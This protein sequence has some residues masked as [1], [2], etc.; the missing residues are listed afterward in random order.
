MPSLRAAAAACALF[1]LSPALRAAEPVDAGVLVADDDELDPLLVLGPATSAKSAD[2]R[3]AISEEIGTS[4]PDS[5]AQN[6]VGATFTNNLTGIINLGDHWSIDLGLLVSLAKGSPPPA[7]SNFKDSGGHVSLFTL[8]A[9]WDSGD[10]W[11]FGLLTDLS[12]KST[13]NSSTTLNTQ[14]GNNGATTQTDARLGVTSSDLDLQAGASYD[15]NGESNLEWLFTGNLTGSHLDTNQQVTAV[16]DRQTMRDLDAA[17]LR[18]YC[19]SHPKPCGKSLNSALQDRDY[20]LDSL[21][22]D[23]GGTATIFTSTDIALTG[24]LYLYA[25]DPGEVGYFNVATSG[26][27]LAG[28]A[29]VPIAPLRANGRLDLVHRFGDLSIRVWGSAGQYAVAGDG[30]TYG[31]GIRVQYK[32]TRTFRMWLS[33]NVQHDVDDTGNNFS[34]R[35]LSLGA[36]LRF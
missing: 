34:T 4:Q 13:T 9:D 14:M 18:A 26:R 33:G 20:H 31:S 10:H 11:S 15:T 5:T 30:T 2:S 16:Y 7:G 21:K 28:G 19:A 23:L 27:A 29:G 35:G 32:F 8:G 12:P 1:A 3:A 22:L 17:Q 25:Q 6:P 36:G 24:G